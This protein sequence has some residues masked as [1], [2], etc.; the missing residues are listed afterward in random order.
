MDRTAQ[1]TPDTL[2]T[3]AAPPRPESPEARVAFE[4]FALASADGVTTVSGGFWL[5][6]D[7]RPPAATLQVVH[8]MTEHIGRYDP[9]ARRLALMGCAVAAHDHVGH[10][11]SVSTPENPS[12]SWGHF[13]PNAGAEHLVEDVQ[14]VRRLVE[15]RFPGVPHA[16][17]GH[18]MGSFVSRAFVGRHGKGLDA[19]IFC[20]TG[21]QPPVALAVG[22]AVTSVMGALFGWNHVSRFVEGLVVGAYARRFSAE[23][24]PLAWLS[25]DPDSNEAYRRD[26]ACGFPF[27]VAGYHELF[28]LISMAQDRSL[29]AAMPHDLPVLL[30][31]GADDPVGNM[32]KGAPKVASLLESCGIGDVELHLY[33][34]ARHE[35]LNETNRDE[36]FADIVAW[37]TEKGVLHAAGEV[38]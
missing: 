11:K 30:L 13:E 10:G 4:P 15:G 31:S 5:P 8:G 12:D 7:S 16:L 36:V 32:G 18:S 25:R 28:R 37:L 17:F 29:V 3:A 19:A 6:P 2:E 14:S 20:G 38:G 23:N 34:G 27:T 33:P 26:E 24:D 21:W 22:R 9:F 35:L 1:S